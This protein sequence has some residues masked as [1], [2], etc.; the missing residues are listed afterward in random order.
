[1]LPQPLPPLT[2]PLGSHVP[3]WDRLTTP[4]YSRILEDPRVW[5]TMFQPPYLQ[6]GSLK[7]SVT[8]MPPPTPIM[9]KHKWDLLEFS[10]MLPS[11][12]KMKNP[13]LSLLLATESQSP[14][15]PLP[16]TLKWKTQSSRP[17]C[18][19]RPPPAPKQGVSSKMTTTTPRSSWASL[20]ASEKLAI[21]RK[22]LAGR[23][24]LPESIKYGS[25]LPPRQLS[26]FALHHS[27]RKPYR[28]LTVLP[29]QFN[30]VNPS[31]VTPVGIGARGEEHLLYQE[32]WE[33]FL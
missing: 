15:P 14:S 32:Y 4:L 1:M 30:A 28:Q 26:Q 22:M 33:L 12:K 31:L 8:P 20:T 5:G 29:W 25:T 27:R 6:G 11:P 9:L 10:L 18:V 24:Y 16:M 3:L 7:L 23:G 19:S 17:S 2:S 13:F 21:H